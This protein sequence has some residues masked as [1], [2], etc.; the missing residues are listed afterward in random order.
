M[1]V[2]SLKIAKTAFALNS[3]PE[4]SCGVAWSVPISSLYQSLGLGI[5]ETL[6][7]F[8]NKPLILKLM[9]GY[10]DSIQQRA[11]DFATRFQKQKE[12]AAFFQLYKFL[13]DP[14]YTAQQRFQ[15]LN[16]CLETPQQ[17]SAALDYG[18][19]AVL[20]MIL[21]G[22]VPRQQDIM[23]GQDKGDL[24]MLLLAFA[25]TF[26][27]KLIVIQQ[28]EQKSEFVKQ[29]S[30]VY[31]VIYL[32]TAEGSYYGLYTREMIEIESNPSFNEGILD[33]EPLIFT[34]NQL[35]KPDFSENPRNLDQILNVLEPPPVL[36][37]A[38][39]APRQNFLPPPP[40][41]QVNPNIS[42]AMRPEV[43][44][45]IE[46]MATLIVKHQI[47]DIDTIQAIEKARSLAPELSRLKNLIEVTKII[48]KT[49][50][51]PGH[52]PFRQASN[53][54]NRLNQADPANINLNQINPN[55]PNVPQRP[56]Y[57]DN[58]VQKLP[59]PPNFNQKLPGV[60]DAMS[61]FPNPPD[62]NQKPPGTPILNQ[63]FTDAGNF[64]QKLPEVPN[65][66]QRLA[67]PPNFNQRPPDS[68]QNF[69]QR[70]PPIPTNLNPISPNTP[71]NFNQRPPEVPQNFNQRPPDLPQNFNQ[72]PPEVPQNFNQRPPDPS[73]NL[74]QRPPDYPQNFNQRL[75][76]PPQNFNQRLPEVPQNFNQRPP[77][78]HQNFNQRLPDPPQNFNQRPPEVPQNFNQRPPDVP[79]Y[80][81]RPPPVAGN[82]EAPRVNMNNFA[83]NALRNDNP[84]PQRLIPQEPQIVCEGCNI[85]RD[86]SVY[87]IRCSNCNICPVCRNNNNQCIKCQRFYSDN[88]MVM[89]PI[90][91]DSL[92]KN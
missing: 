30:G 71:A 16:Q 13:V 7:R 14:G 79:N 78:V 64:N 50:P 57:A 62:F 18:T 44:D 17:Y 49:N 90:Y 33:K 72:R 81:Q 6:L 73:Q 43:M 91:A 21:D 24:P 38:G 53:E 5:F 55:L 48:A 69:N 68:P 66:N 83:N 40:K 88:E 11:T 32:Y 76:V 45:L 3:F 87:E 35:N 4:I 70:G 77:D 19:R 86:E 10:L 34:I 61:T 67:D 54:S 9:K 2:E 28:N 8:S 25:E 56:P 31:P 27:V 12:V 59:D 23:N 36:S 15:S 89:I 41:E 42:Q 47:Y 22:K 92:R 29:I 51:P 20:C 58:F 75:P 46:K 65:F 74:N 39:P 52:Q 26:Q 85:P 80:N 63:R 1:S 82:S 60:A 37:M 84:P